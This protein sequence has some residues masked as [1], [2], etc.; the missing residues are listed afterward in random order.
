MALLMCIACKTG[1]AA[2]PM[3]RPAGTQEDLHMCG[4]DMSVRVVCV[5]QQE[6]HGMFGLQDGMQQYSTANAR[7]VQ[8]AGETMSGTDAWQIIRLTPRHAKKR[9]VSSAIHSVSWE[10]PACLHQIMQPYKTQT[11]Q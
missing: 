6:H 4:C 2:I 8:H 5:D 11:M 9:L 1:T 3:Y 10:Q 7:A